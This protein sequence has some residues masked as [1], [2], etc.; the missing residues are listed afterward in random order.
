[1]R[2]ITIIVAFLLCASGCF[3]QQS[4]SCEVFDL[5]RCRETAAEFNHNIRGVEF[6]LRAAEYQRKEARGISPALI[7]RPSDSILCTRCSE[8]V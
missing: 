1:M 5:R 8:S 7:L 4:R 2:K 6:D 3:A